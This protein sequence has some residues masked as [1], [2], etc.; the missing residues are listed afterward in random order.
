MHS[1]PRGVLP[2]QTSAPL[3]AGLEPGLFTTRLITWVYQGQLRQQGFTAAGHLLFDAQSTT[4][5]SHRGAPP[6]LFTQTIRYRG[7]DFQAG[8]WWHNIYRPAGYFGYGGLPSSCRNLGGGLEPPVP[9][10]YS[11]YNWS[12]AIRLALQCGHYDLGG[13]QRVDGVEAIKLV[14]RTPQTG[15]FAKHKVPVLET[16]WVD[17]STY[18]PMRVLW[19]WPE[20]HG[21][22]DGTLVSDFR[23]LAPT[24]ANLAALR[25]KIPHGFR[26]VTLATGLPQFEFEISGQSS[27]Q[28]RLA[29]GAARHDLAA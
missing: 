3:R 27:W 24:K 28:P 14:E 2:P 21:Q 4:V 5:N 6:G 13:R 23:W 19:Q 7:A 9:V 22:P 26:K 10:Q 12:A 1:L 8:T 18:L 29:G 17:P 15:P 11:P 25:V 20:A 16:L